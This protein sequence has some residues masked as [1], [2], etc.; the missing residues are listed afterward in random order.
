MRQWQN[1]SINLGP[2]DYKYF[3]TVVAG[4]DCGV[5]GIRHNHSFDLEVRIAA[6]DYIAA[7]WQNTAK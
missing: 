6:N 1:L 4:V 2:T 7:A 5:E 3:F